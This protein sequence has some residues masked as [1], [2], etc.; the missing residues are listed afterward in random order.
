M[1]EVLDFIKRRFSKDCNWLDNN[2]YYFSLILKNRFSQGVIFYDVINGHFI[3]QC[4]SKYYDWSG[5]IQPNGHLV[6][7]DKFDEYDSLQK[8][9]IIRDCVM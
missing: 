5:E 9:H 1:N 3:F 8:Q 6:E 7:W 4:N 2:C